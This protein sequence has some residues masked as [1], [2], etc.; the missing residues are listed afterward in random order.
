MYPGIHRVLS[1]SI[2]FV[3]EWS[4]HPEMQVLLNLDPA[5][6]FL[7]GRSSRRSISSPNFLLLDGMPIDLSVSAGTSCFHTV[8]FWLLSD[9][10]LLYFSPLTQYRLDSR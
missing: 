1:L 5:T 8:H 7:W 9:M 3:Y 10:P 2:L 4:H 6:A